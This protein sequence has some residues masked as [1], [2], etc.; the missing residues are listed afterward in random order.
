MQEIPPPY[1]PHTP[2]TH[3]PDLLK[4]IIVWLSTHLMKLTILTDMAD[5]LI[6]T[7]VCNIPHPPILTIPNSYHTYVTL[8]GYSLLPLIHTLSCAYV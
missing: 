4:V 7:I 3:L 6:L 1:P 8:H 2:S 5:R